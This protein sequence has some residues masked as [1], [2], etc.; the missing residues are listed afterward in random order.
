MGI[1]G[2]LLNLAT[3]G[4]GES[5]RK[6]KSKRDVEELRLRAEKETEQHNAVYNDLL[7]KEKG[8]YIALRERYIVDYMFTHVMLQPVSKRDFTFLDQMPASYR[9]GKEFQ[10]NLAMVE[11]EYY[12]SLVQSFKK[13]EVNLPIAMKALSQLLSLREL[14][15]DIKAMLTNQS[16]FESEAVSSASIFTDCDDFDKILQA[17]HSYHINSLLKAIDSFS[18][19]ITAAENG[20]LKDALKFWMVPEYTKDD[21][22]GIKIG[23]L[24]LAFD[25]EPDEAIVQLY[26]VCQRICKW[27]FGIGVITNKD[28]EETLVLYPCVDMVIAEVMRHIRSGSADQYNDQLQDWLDKCGDVLKYGQL[29]VLQKVFFNLKAFDQEKI[30]LEYMVRTNTARTAEQNQR[31]KFFNERHSGSVSVNA[32]LRAINLA[33]SDINGKILYDHRFVNWRANDIQ[34]YFDNL[35]LLQK[36]QDFYIV[37]DEWQKDINVPGINW[38]NNQI[39]KNISFELDQRFGSVYDVSVVPS[40]A[41][42]EGWIDVLPSIY[43][44]TKDSWARNS[45]LS[46]IVT[47]EQI[48]K[49][50]LHLSIMVLLSSTD[51]HGNALGNEALCNKTIA[52]KEKYNPRTETYISTM[53]NTLI[54]Q[55]ESWVNSSSYSQDIY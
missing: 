17:V 26:D 44:H 4:A 29:N 14:S 40:G 35:T 5:M 46:F 37:I 50:T 43:I 53:K 51:S 13:D 34:N 20:N 1:F 28:G 16:E 38:D 31:L 48:T 25:D 55:L 15:D 9:N 12:S 32:G 2:D 39:A 30:V 33:D 42:I 47:G 22:N 52:V 8:R 23:L 54:E 19:G 36:S 21:L 49:S 45:E 10:R 11:E 27:L 3:Q 41:A 24:G 18:D 7:K 6:A